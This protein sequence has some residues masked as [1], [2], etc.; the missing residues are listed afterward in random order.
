M[1]RFVVA[2]PEENLTHHV[3]AD[4]PRRQ[5]HLAHQTEPSRPREE[6]QHV[7]IVNHARV[8]VPAAKKDCKVNLVRRVRWVGVED[9]LQESQASAW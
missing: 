6:A 2:T 9:P 7:A 4:N 1:L 3:M 8:C 5:S